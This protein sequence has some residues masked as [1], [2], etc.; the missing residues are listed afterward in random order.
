MSAFSASPFV[1]L[2]DP[3]GAYQF[4]LRTDILGT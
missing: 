4:C 1:W 3:T 2:L